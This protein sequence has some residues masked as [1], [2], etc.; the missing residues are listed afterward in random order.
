M[1]Y[2]F[3]LILSV[4]LVSMLNYVVSAILGVEFNFMNGVYVSLIFAVLVFII[5]AIIPNES[6]PDKEDHAH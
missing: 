2:I 5:A 4:L 6:T 1:R 3:G